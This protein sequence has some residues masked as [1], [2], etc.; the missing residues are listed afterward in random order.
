MFS[1]QASPTVITKSITRPNTFLAKIVVLGAQG[2]GKTALL[3]RYINNSFQNEQRPTI[4]AN[5]LI[6]RMLSTDTNPPTAFKLQI[7]DTAGQERFRS[8]SKLYYR[9]ANAALLCYDIT[10]EQSFLEMGTWMEELRKNIG[11]ECLIHVVG[12]KAD[13]VEEEPH[14]RQVP[15]ERCIQ[16]V[17]DQLHGSKPSTAPSTP[18]GARTISFSTNSPQTPGADP[19]N[20]GFWGFDVGWDSCHEISAK[21]GD[22]VEEVFRV[23]TRKLVEQRNQEERELERQRIASKTSG[24]GDGV[25]C[26]ER[27]GNGKGSFRLGLAKRRS[28][29]SAIAGPGDSTEPAEA[30]R[31][32]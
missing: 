10:D 5:F 29:I 12:T 25:G 21:D 3:N 13:V 17:S 14:K 16:Y 4:G 28:W 9:G 7:W 1:S 23:L 22:G 6:K 26:F 19:R 20:S 32:C 27:N 11:K 31:C 24:A 30:G 2:V 18:G 8:I 15:F